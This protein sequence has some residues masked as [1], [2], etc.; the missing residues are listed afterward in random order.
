MRRSIKRFS[1]ATLLALTAALA[2]SAIVSAATSGQVSLRATGVRFDGR[3]NFFPSSANHGGM[4]YPGFI[5][6]TSTDGNPVRVHAKVEGYGYGPSTWERRGNGNC[7][8]EN[9]YVYDPAALYVLT[10][11]IEACQDRGILPDVCRASPTYA[12]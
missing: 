7:A 5:C 6:D 10:G 8:A 12:R 2:I 9:K 3:Y 11:K 1:L 4:G